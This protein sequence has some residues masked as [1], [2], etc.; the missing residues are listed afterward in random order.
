MAPIATIIRIAASHGK[1]KLVQPISLENQTLAKTQKKHWKTLKAKTKNK[2][3]EK[4]KK[5]NNSRDGKPHG[6]L[7]SAC[8][9]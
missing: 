2:V 3:L 4:L 7:G 6:C 5:L 8:H 9:P 1:L